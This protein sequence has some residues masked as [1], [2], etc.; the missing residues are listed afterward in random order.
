MLIHRLLQFVS[1]QALIKTGGHCVIALQQVLV[2][3]DTFFHVAF[4]RLVRVQL[5]FLSEIA[6]DQSFRHERLAGMVAKF[7]CHDPEQRTLPSSIQ[8]EHPN[9]GAR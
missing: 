6:N 3:R 8:P 1:Y 5:R 9:L 4:D 7:T 2:F